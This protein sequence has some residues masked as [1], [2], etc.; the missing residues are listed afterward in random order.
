MYKDKRSV[1]KVEKMD[2]KTWKFTRIENGEPISYTL[3]KMEEARWLYKE[4][5]KEY[6]L[7]KCTEDEIKRWKADLGS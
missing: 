5:N 2:K 6:E 1:S 3:S 7:M 4:D